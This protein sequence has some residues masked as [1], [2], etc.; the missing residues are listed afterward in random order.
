MFFRLSLW[1]KNF[2]LGATLMLHWIFQDVFNPIGPAVDCKVPGA[3]LNDLREE[4]RKKKD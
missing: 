2:R 4:Q 3:Y 1:S